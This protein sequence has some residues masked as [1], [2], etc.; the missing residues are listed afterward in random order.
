MSV[1]G[2][3]PAHAQSNV[4]AYGVIDTLVTRIHADGLPATTRMDTSGL[5]ASRI[6]FRGR[7]DLG[8][9]A[10]ANFALELGLNGD[11]GT[12]GDIRGMQAGILHTF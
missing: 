4:T 5:L 7:E 9:G 8:G 10:S 1:F 12:G 3:M 6:G 2:C 11:D